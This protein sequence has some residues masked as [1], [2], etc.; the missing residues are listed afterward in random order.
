MAMSLNMML[1]NYPSPKLQ[2]LRKPE[3]K[4][5][6]TWKRNAVVSS[7]TGNDEHWNFCYKTLQKVSRTFSGI[8]LQL[9]Q[10]QLRDAVC[11]FFRYLNTLTP[12]PCLWQDYKV[13]DGML[14]PHIAI[15]CI[16]YEA[17]NQTTKLYHC[18]LQVC[19]LYLALRAVDTVGT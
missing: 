5:A 11:I 12:L 9:S 16:C 3:I 7:S 17:A 18:F 10:P 13:S 15:N 14:K 1:I 6:T 8:T 19:V 4:T 2:L